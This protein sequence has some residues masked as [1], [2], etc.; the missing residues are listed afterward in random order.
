MQNFDV[1]VVGGGPAGYNSAEYAAHQG[2]KVLLVEKKSLGGT[3][4]NVGCIPTK[5]F[6]YA[7]KMYHY[8]S[9]AG[10]AYGVTAEGPVHVDQAAV[11]AKKDEVVKMLVQG[12]G[13]ALRRSK[14]KVVNGTAKLGRA[15]GK[16]AVFVGDETYTAENLILAT[17]STPAVP[18]IE[19]V[20]EGMADGTVMTS[21]EILDMKEIPKK[22]LVVGGGVIG[23]E[24]AAYFQEVGAKVTVI[25]ML[26]KVLG[27]NDR[28][29]SELLQKE[30]EKKGVTFH[31]SSG[32]KKLAGGVV[33]YEK[34]GRLQLAAYDKALMCVGR[35]ANSQIEGLEELGVQTERGAIVTDE[36]MQT[37]VPHVYAIGDVN[38]KVMLAHVGYREGEVA[39]NHI[40]GEDDTMSYDAISGVVYTSPEA[41]FVG[42]SE[43]QA[44][45]SGR[46]YEVKKVSIN[47]SG[48]HVAENGLSNGI[49]KLIVDKNKETLIGAA[50]MSSYA[51]EYIYALALMID[52]QLPLRQV[53]R[54]IFPHPTVC[55]IVREALMN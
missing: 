47:F 21:D 15:D 28:E 18:P 42:L 36:H 23:F 13:S 11:V 53:R 49:C 55:E 48:R 44:K 10:E 32:V 46:N 1:I 34:D 6:L 54:T 27:G 40:L 29:V 2:K 35:R 9:G 7:G 14:V 33:T 24:M 19:G 41:A 52:L 50:L 3:C 8:A 39:V 5:T 20:K 51:S 25:E 16:L 43:E 37:S 30:L 45:A 12:V 4:L 38:G 17:G 22:L 31:L 26:D